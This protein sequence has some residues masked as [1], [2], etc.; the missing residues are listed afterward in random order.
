MMGRRA[1]LSV[2]AA[3]AILCPGCSG[4]ADESVD[5]TTTTPASSLEEPAGPGTVSDEEFDGIVEE[6][7]D[8]LTAGD[9]DLCTLVATFLSPT[10]VQP[11]TPAQVSAAV[12]TVAGFLER[13]VALDAV[14]DQ[15]AAVLAGAAERL[16]DDAERAGYSV[17]FFVGGGAER[18]FADEA[19]SAALTRVMQAAA[20]QCG[21]EVFGPMDPES[22]I[23]PPAGGA[24]SPED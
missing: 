2:L 8:E 9:A 11:S 12:E 14:D 5:T 24:S 23:A 10:D 20:D 22:G 15:S 6:L 18:L 21:P 13:I 3:T 1:L 4:T 16:R 7:T 17:D 19:V